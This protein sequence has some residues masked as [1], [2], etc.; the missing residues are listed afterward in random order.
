MTEFSETVV[1]DGL[2]RFIPGP[3]LEKIYI[4]DYSVY[5]F[6]AD[7]AEKSPRGV[8]V[9]D[10]GAGRAYFAPLFRDRFYVPVD[11]MRGDRNWDYGKIKTGANLD[12]L[13]FKDGAFD[14]IICT[15]V[16]EH[17][18]E[19]LLVLRELGRTLTKDGKLLITVPQG[20][21]EHQEPRD[22]YRY[23]R[24]GLEYLLEK[25]GFKRW[26]IEPRGGFFRFMGA[27]I[28]DLPEFMFGDLM[29]K[30]WF[31]PVTFL[32]KAIFMVVLPFVCCYLDVLDRK[33]VLTNG[34]SC[35]AEK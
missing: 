21:R 6:V 8:T 16:L 22:Y 4:E 23:T 31:F 11:D 20:W 30:R 2:N 10:A 19:P 26:R 35:K 32:M 29:K 33:K 18:P 27:H 34:Y 12:R 25:A 9:L 14:L 17:V 7:E 5:R 28:R 3:L 13:P 1:F 15:Q 24:Y